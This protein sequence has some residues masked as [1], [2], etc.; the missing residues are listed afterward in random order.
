MPMVIAPSGWMPPGYGRAR[1]ALTISASAS[2]LPTPIRPTRCRNGAR[3]CVGYQIFP[4]RFRREGDAEQALE[5]W[6]SA[7]VQSEFRFGGNINGIRAAIPYLKKLGVQMIYTTPLFESD[8][9]HRYNTFDYYRIDPLLGTEGDLKAL[10]D[11]LHLNGMRIVLDGVFN[12]CGLGFAPFVDARRRVSRANTATGFTLTMWKLA[13]TAPLVTN[14]I[15]PS[16]TCAMRHAPSTFS[17]WASTGLNLRYRR[18]AVGCKPG[19]MARVLVA[20][21]RHDE[22]CESRKPHD[23]RMLG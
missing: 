2:P 9:A 20:L 14:P 19:S 13:A 23:C 5:P 4:D 3:G 1:K 8:S 11:E 7:R 18:L 6:N 16:S 22:T 21:P 17:R 15:C 12:H 10:C